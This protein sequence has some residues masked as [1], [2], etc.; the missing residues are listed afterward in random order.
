MSKDEAVARAK[1]GLA[2]MQRHQVRDDKSG[3]LGRFPMIYN[4]TG[5]R[6][7]RL[8]TNW[9]TGV[10]VQAFLAAYRLT[11]DQS[12]LDAAGLGVG[13]I[14]SLQSFSPTRPRMAGTFHEICPQS[15]LSCPRDAT[16]AA[17]ALWDWSKVTGDAD[18]RER[19]LLFADWFLR[20]GMET[21]IPY[22]NSYF[23]DRPWDPPWS[24]SFHIGEAIYL[25]RLYQDTQDKNQG[26][27]YT[28]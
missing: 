28:R 4:C 19:S 18:A 27:G 2:F 3:D 22:W 12:Y 26:T 13:Y 17:W 20:V 10:A 24:G 1:A 16:T 8:S 11:G 25:F 23:D 15:V 14:K 21:G 9:T 6:L 7:I 5:C